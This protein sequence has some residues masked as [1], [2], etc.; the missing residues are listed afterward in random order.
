MS[1]ILD[2]PAVRQAALL[3]SVEQYHRL[4]ESG[5][6]SAN[7]ELLRGVI[8]EKMIKSPIHSW[9]VQ[10]LV[11][12]LRV[13]LSSDLHVRQQQP[14]TFADSEPEPDVAVVSGLR[15]DYRTTHPSTAVLV[16][17]VALSSVELDREKAKLYAAAGV[18]EYLV[19]VPEAKCVEAYSDVR[20]SK[21]ANVRTWR[22][23]ESLKLTSFPGLALQINELFPD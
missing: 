10:F 18:I 2:N 23:G 8:V 4:G 9:L 14:L 1:S 21:Y 17:E 16:I 6:V 19:V 22:S 7:T 13:D 12:W 3:V 20:S 5:L 11:E 15:D